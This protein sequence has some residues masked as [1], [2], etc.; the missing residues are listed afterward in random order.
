MFTF[1][2][3]SAQG[4]NRTKVDFPL[5][6][7]V[8]NVTLRSIE[9]NDKILGI[10]FNFQRVD[11]DT[12][13]FLTGSILPPK[14][15]WFTEAK[16]IKDVVITADEQF[17]NS[18]KSFMGYVNHILIAAGVASDALKG[19]TGET[20]DDLIDNV[21]KAASPLIDTKATFYLKTVKD[22]NGYTKIPQYRGTGVAQSTDLG[23][24]SKFAYT[25][26]EQD[27]MDA[28][29]VEGVED[30]TTSST[31]SSGLDF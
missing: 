31:K 22:K 10:N 12:I 6:L 5:D 11:G 8:S 26:Y 13:S 16:K 30:N 21:V 29:D 23:Y 17:M 9:K 3:D 2:T 20:L 14:K 1:N 18:V 19:I 28:M 7:A 24:P 25:T 15:E 4:A 27:I